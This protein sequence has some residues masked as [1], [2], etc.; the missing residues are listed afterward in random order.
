MKEGSV[1]DAK[2]DTITAKLYN[3]KAKLDTITTCNGH[4]SR[5]NKISAEQADLDIE[6]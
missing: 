1:V 4:I 6:G 5:E 2:L 3:V